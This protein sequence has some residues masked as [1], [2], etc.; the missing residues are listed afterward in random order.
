MCA[1]SARLHGRDDLLPGSRGRHRHLMGGPG[2]AG[3]LRPA[4]PVSVGAS[5]LPRLE[6]QSPK[7][8]K[9]EDDYSVIGRL[10][11]IAQPDPAPASLGDDDTLQHRNYAARSYRQPARGMM[12][13][14]VQIVF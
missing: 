11:T 14:V 5:F 13:V 2:G 9:K 3:G 7:G 4:G 6:L 10:R 8:W 12:Q 1:A